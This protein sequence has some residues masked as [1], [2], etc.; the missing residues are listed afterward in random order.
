MKFLPSPRLLMV[1]ALI[2]LGA[3]FFFPLWQILL[4]AAQFPGGLQLYIWVNKISG[5]DK[6][7]LQNINILNHYIGM[8]AIYPDSIPELK[9]FPL[10]VYGMLGLGV[11]TVFI[12]KAWG[13]LTW[14]IILA[15]L[16]ILGI[17]DFYLWLYDYGH[18]LDPN[19]P[20]KVEGMTYMPP[21]FGD[22]DLLNF[23]VQS[24][25]HWG[26]IFLGLSIIIAGL[27]YFKKRSQAKLIVD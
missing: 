25:P 8:K 4:D 17:Y 19:A 24:Y 14:A 9:Y 16:G 21:L 13:Y 12:N 11:V 22:K 18:N 20:I 5:T 2:C 7:I 6:Y 23:Y 3:V 10:V 15:V 26:G 27:A 1:L